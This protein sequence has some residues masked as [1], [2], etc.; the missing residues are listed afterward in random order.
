MLSVFSCDVALGLSHVAQLVACLV[1]VTLLGETAPAWPLNRPPRSMNF[2]AMCT[3]RHDGFHTFP[4]ARSGRGIGLPPNYAGELLFVLSLWPLLVTLFVFLEDG[5]ATTPSSPSGP[6]RTKVWSNARQKEEPP[7]SPM[8]Q[9]RPY[10][11][12]SLLVDV[13]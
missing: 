10:R 2:V 12:I 6:P 9:H 1:H 8:H 3:S 5:Y 7:K 11:L 4:Y 13:F